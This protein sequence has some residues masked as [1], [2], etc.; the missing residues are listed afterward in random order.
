M[1][2]C[3]PT[4]EVLFKEYK[5][6]K[7][8]AAAAAERGEIRE[9]SGNIE[10]ADFVIAWYE[11]EILCLHGEFLWTRCRDEKNQLY[12]HNKITGESTREMPEDVNLMYGQALI[13][14]RLQE[15]AAKE[16]GLPGESRA[17]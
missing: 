6:S 17:V 16:E 3:L 2:G 13:N 14:T 7:G 9:R 5:R 15:E 10:I 12:Y 1:T 8:R 4:E 11:T